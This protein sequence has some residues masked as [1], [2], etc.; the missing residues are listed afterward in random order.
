MSSADAL[1]A[2]WGPGLHS[3]CSQDKGGS[4]HTDGI[5]DSPDALLDA[6]AERTAE[7]AEVWFGAHPLI[8]RPSDNKRGGGADI[9]SV[10]VLI[11]DLDW[12]HPG[13]HSAD[14]PP[15]A[16]IR[17]RLHLV[18]MQPRIIINSGHGL[19]CYWPIEE[20]VSPDEGAALQNA[21]DALLAGYGLSNDR[22]DL[23]SVMRVP[24]SVNFKTEP[25]PVV[26]EAMKP[27]RIPQSVIEKRLAEHRG[28]APAPTRSGGGVNTR[29]LQAVLVELRD[30]GR[31]QD[32]DALDVLCRVH[33]G[34]H[35]YLDRQGGI[36]ATRPGKAAGGSAS[37]G[38]VSPGVVK[39]FTPNWEPFHQDGRYVLDGGKLI[40]TN[41]ARSLAKSSSAGEPVE[42][43]VVDLVVGSEVF[44]GPD[45]L[46]YTDVGNAHRF[47]DRHGDLV[48]RVPRWGRWLVFDGGRWRI[49]YGDT[50]VRHIASQIAVE[51]LGH[52]SEVRQDK[53][54]LKA[55]M[56]HAKRAESAPGITAT[57]EVAASIPGV[58]IDHEA[59]DADPWLLN[60]ANGTLE[61]SSGTMRDHDPAD[62][63][64][65]QASA[66]F[67]ADATAPAFAAFLEQILPDPE[68]RGL[69]QRLAGLALVGTQLE[70]VLPICLGTGANGKS[71]LTR[72]MERTLGEYSIVASKDVLLALK[73]STHPT[74]KAGLFRRRFAHSGE[75]P[76]TAKLDEAQIK[77]LTGGDRI[78]ARRMREDFWEFDPSHLLWIHANHRPTIEGTD[79]G[80]WRRVLLIPFDVQIPEADRDAHLAERIVKTESA[81]V[82]NWMIAGLADYLEAGLSVPALVANA[83]K[84]YRGES[85]T[86][87]TFLDESGLELAPGLTL[88][89]NDL[90]ALHGEW[91]A[92]SGSTE[93]EAAHYQR[94]V[95]D[96]KEQG[97]TTGR[98]GSR[99][100]FWRGLGEAS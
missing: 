70:H 47:L 34:H 69:V 98:T 97:A 15:E 78:T 22:G 19:Q 96:L 29:G 61:L 57:L 60:V 75:L 8:E 10:S 48:R 74:A 39:V 28:Q 71:T 13:A 84:A 86:V 63:L 17:E 87:A 90:V 94:V 67:H 25:V 37:V 92:A 26:V 51:L 46:R 20:T 42:A 24:G 55:L 59:F 11:A 30:L 45:G 85:D 36:Y 52:V 49:D 21:L 91:F 56:R 43:E 65:M 35:P 54:R 33:G 31:D 88:P 32:A 76:P 38:Y 82:L 14:H 66:E 1:A 5:F 7:G 9:S 80:I 18:P 81:G 73:H 53:D 58:A 40:A 16:E 72:V 2:I 23:A 89:S 95:H 50:F 93:P 68:V 100:R 77:E 83:T 4:F 62:H 12:H 27:G 79:D 41:H 99:G 6:A 3:L 44:S 64:T